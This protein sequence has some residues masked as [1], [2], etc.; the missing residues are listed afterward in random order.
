FDTNL[1]A[2][3][4]FANLGRITATDSEVNL[5]GTLTQAGLGYFVR[6]RGIVKVVTGG[7][8]VGDVTLDDTTGPWQ[9]AG[10]EIRYGHVRTSGS[11]VLTASALG[12]T[13]RGVT[14]DG[15]L[16]MPRP[17]S[18]TATF[19]VQEGLTLNSTL[20]LGDPTGT[21]FFT[22]VQFGTGAQ[23]LDGTGTVVFGPS[24][25]NALFGSTGTT[26]TIGPGVT[27][28]GQSGAINTLTSLEN[29]GTIAADVAGG[30][31]D[32]SPNSF[33]NPGTVRAANGGTVLVHPTTT[34]S[35][36]TDALTTGTITAGSLTGG[37]WSV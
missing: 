37:T 31:I 9:L 36:L 18:G 32:V 14:L 28:R 5:K 6:T 21:T 11:G 2:T 27:V 4:A 10:G 25:G 12:G 30:T 20:Q 34:L 33:T 7:T 13:L 17:T 24:A 26:L 19:V 22:S 3:D 23:T 29:R 35:N 16:T 1:Q 8:V 15:T